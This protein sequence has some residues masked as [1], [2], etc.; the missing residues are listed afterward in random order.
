MIRRNAPFGPHGNLGAH[1]SAA[2][3]AGVVAA[4]AEFL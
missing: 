2:D 1:A 4:Q 3:S